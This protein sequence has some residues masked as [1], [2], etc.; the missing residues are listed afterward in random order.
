MVTRQLQAEHRTCW[1][2]D[3][4]LRHCSSQWLLVA[5]V[6]YQAVGA[7]DMFENSLLH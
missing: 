2:I 7:T 6:D 3:M 5:M 1:M 4:A